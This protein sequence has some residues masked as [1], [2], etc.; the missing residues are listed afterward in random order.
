M[1]HNRK[2]QSDALSTSP[3]P[4]SSNDPAFSQ[5]Q[6]HAEDLT[7]Y[8]M[9]HYRDDLTVG[10]SGEMN[11]DGRAQAYAKG[12]LEGIEQAWREDFEVGTPD[13]EWI[14]KECID[15]EMAAEGFRMPKG[16]DD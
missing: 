3:F 16:N 14:I 10:P 7:A 12:L 5:L 15:E 11:P 4:T 1:T 9:D 6:N 13:A 8:F 2:W